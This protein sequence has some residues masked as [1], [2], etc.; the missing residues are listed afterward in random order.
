MTL[1]RLRQY[2]CRPRGLSLI[3]SVV[4]RRWSG[5]DS[6]DVG[7]TCRRLDLGVTSERTNR[8]QTLTECQSTGAN[9][10]ANSLA[11]WA[12]LSGPLQIYS[13]LERP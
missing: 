4:A 11:V 13:A 6:R 10:A 12:T 1:C 3:L 8:D 5:W 9:C 2:R 7:I